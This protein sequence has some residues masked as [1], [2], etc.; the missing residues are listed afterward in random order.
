MELMALH[1]PRPPAGLQT[2]RRSLIKHLSLGNKLSVGFGCM[3]LIAAGLGIANYVGS[4]KNAAKIHGLVEESLP[5]TEALLNI[6]V[7]ANIVKSGLRTLLS[8]D[9]DPAVRKL[10]VENIA[11][12]RATY[13]D[14]VKVFEAIPRDAERDALWQQFQADLKTWRE[15]NN[16]FLQLSAEFDQLS[17]NF[18]RSER[19]KS[20][21]YPT[22]LQKA[23][24]L[25]TNTKAEFKEQI[26]EWKNILLRGHNTNDFSK[27]LDA[28]N[29]QEKIVQANLTGLQGL[30]HDL[31]LSTTA[32]EKLSASNLELG[33]QYLE[34]LKNFNPTAP[35]TA[36]IVDQQ[37]K[38]KDRPITEAIA[39]ASGQ[40]EQATAKV[41]QLAVALDHQLLVVALEAQRKADTS[42]DQ[43]LQDNK[44]RVSA[45]AQHAIG[46]C[47]F[48]KSFAIIMTL[49]GI[50]IGIVLAWL[51][52]RSI[53][54]PI[55]AVAEILSAGASET[56]SAA[57]EV[58]SASQ[59]LA[60]G[61]SEQAASIEETSASIEEMS[62]MTKH[63]VET[64]QKAN[65][66]AKQARSA[67]EKGSID[68]QSMSTAMNDIN[69]SSADIAKILK[70]IDEIAF[71]TNLLALNAAV[72]A[73]RAGEA[74]AGFA[75][76]AEEVRALAQ[77][78]A[79]AAKETSVEIESAISKTAQG[80]EISTK[81]ATVLVDIV[82][83]AR[84]V[85]ELVTEMTSASTEQS[86]SISQVGTTMVE[87]DKVTQGNAASA[88]QTAAA[89]EE[90]N[91]QTISIHDA[92]DQ[93]LQL[94][95][96]RHLNEAVTPPAES[97]ESTRQSAKTPVKSSRPQAKVR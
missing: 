22:A 86:Q 46:L 97:R 73:A 89:A 64:A 83:Q 26:Q 15:A 81:V 6:K 32:T 69:A 25:V 56:A 11:T 78:C 71:Q 29:N 82:T 8:L 94:V 72:E 59:S 53:T 42:I 60:Q 44:K 12:A 33:R 21:R 10:Q 39:A 80:V 52:T 67:A 45:D 4:A 76:V 88:E 79:T 50:T 57:S 38:G 36:K 40:I 1:S 18:N 13:G 20:T 41:T 28:F 90:L 66:L 43:L 70:T 91:A 35:D 68:M 75:V 93:L 16:K 34:A 17:E 27:Y 47:E 48:F 30:L 9:A 87:L 96:G 61:A 84:Q 31:G 5:A 23:A 54:K 65:Q 51:I 58:T 2:A 77:R 62:S 85:D 95:N 7:Q 37:V 19:G 3:M 49:I 63:N 55:Q 92:I 24:D 74:G 14:A